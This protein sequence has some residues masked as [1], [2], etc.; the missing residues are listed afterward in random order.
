M[1]PDYARANH[2]PVAAIGRDMSTDAVHMKVKAGSKVMIDAGRSSDPDGDALTYDWIFYKEPGTYKGELDF[3][4]GNS[5]M[6]LNVPSD[7][8]GRTIHLVLRVTDGGFPALTSYRRIILE[9][10]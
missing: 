10:R 3:A 9:C 2:H 4:N 5:K 7:A 1:T 6:N 8:E